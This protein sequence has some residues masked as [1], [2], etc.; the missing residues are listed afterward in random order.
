MLRVHACEHC[1]VWVQTGRD[2]NLETFHASNKMRHPG[3]HAEGMSN[4]VSRLDY[5]I[6]LQSDTCVCPSCYT[7]YTKFKDTLESPRWLKLRNSFYSQHHCILCCSDSEHECVCKQISEWGPTDISDSDLKLWTRYLVGK[8]VCSFINPIAKSICRYHLRTHK[9]T[10]SSCSNIESTEWHLECDVLH[11]DNY[12]WICDTCVSCIHGKK[13]LDDMLNRQNPVL[14]HRTELMQRALE[15]AKLNSYV[16]NVPLLDK[17]RDLLGDKV[18]QS[19]LKTLGV[20][21]DKYLTVNGLTSYQES[22][23]LGKI[24]YDRSIHSLEGIKHVYKLV[25]NNYK[26]NKENATLKEKEPITPQAIHDMVKEQCTQFPTSATF[27]YR[28]LIKDGYLDDNKLGSIFNSNLVTVIDNITTLDSSKRGTHSKLYSDMRKIRIYMIISL[29]CY[30]LNPS[31]V[32]LQTLIGLFC[33]AYG[34]RDKGFEILNAFGCTCSIDHIR[35]HGNYWATQ[36]NAIDEL[37]TKQLLRVSFDNL[38]YK[39][40]F[41]RNWGIARV[42]VHKEC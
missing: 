18:N 13:R 27:D 31:A 17:Y 40:K 20:S 42:V 26:L 1:S 8:Q 38:N 32:F 3:E 24:Y 37:N 14:K 22:R 28:S 33:Y 2:K 16:Y 10:C 4:F 41:R 15:E 12:S 19:N 30:T 39:I 35:K 7:D 6:I 29:L 21:I 25:I 23:K 11:N 34:L 36:R 9:Q 5:N